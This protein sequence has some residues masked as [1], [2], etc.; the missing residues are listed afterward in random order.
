VQS[1]SREAKPNNE[2]HSQQ[3]RPKLGE[4]PVG[5]N[6]A[7]LKRLIF[8]RI[9]HHRPPFNRLGVSLGDQE[10]GHEGRQICDLHH[11]TTPSAKNLSAGRLR[12]QIMDRPIRSPDSA[13]GATANIE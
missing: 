13:S 6:H 1:T 4:R 11:T 3:K 9:F 2:Q 8:R 12:G 10:L 5:L 7:L